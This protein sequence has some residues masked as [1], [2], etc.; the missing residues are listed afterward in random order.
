MTQARIDR[1]KEVMSKHFPNAV[2][3]ERLKMPPQV[4]KK[5]L[6]PQSQQQTAPA[7][8]QFEG[9]SSA[10]SSPASTPTPSAE[11]KLYKL[12]CIKTRSLAKPLDPKIKREDCVAVEWVV[13]SADKILAAPAKYDPSKRAVAFGTPKPERIWIPNVR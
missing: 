1:A 2:N 4:E 9:S 5:R 13:A 11:E 7:T 12:H 8:Q 3:R 6:P 10:G